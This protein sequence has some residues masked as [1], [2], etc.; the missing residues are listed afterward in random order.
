MFVTRQADYAIRCVLYLSRENKRSA[1][2]GEISRAMHVPRSFLAKIVQRLVKSEL[3]RSTRG[4]NGGLELAKKPND[5]SLFD[6]IQAI[7]G[8]AFI[9]MCATDK[10]ECRLGYTCAVHPVWAKLRKDVEERLKK[11]KF[12]D[13]PA[14]G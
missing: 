4:V 8:S 10:K 1:S 6:V 2:V 13:F 14:K 7:Q 5:I 9:S 3:I 12:S 11:E